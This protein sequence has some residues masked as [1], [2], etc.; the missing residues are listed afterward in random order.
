VD[1]PPVVLGISP[2]RLD[3][4]QQAQIKLYG[5][6]PAQ[7]EDD[8]VVAFGD[9]TTSVFP[10]A[11]GG[12]V[13]TVPGAVTLSEGQMVPFTV[14]ARKRSG[15]FGLWSEDVDLQEQLAV[16]K[17]KPFSCTIETFEVRPD[18]LEKVEAE[19]L[20]SYDAASASQAR[21]SR[22][23]AAADL[24]TQTVRDAASYDPSTAVVLATGEKVF[25][26]G[27]GCGQG[28]SA[29]ARIVESGRAVEID[30]EAPALSRR[31]QIDGWKIQTCEANDT[32]ISLT[33]KPTF[34]AARRDGGALLSR[35][36][37]TLDVGYEGVQLSHHAAAGVPWSVRVSCAFA[38]GPERWQTR[39][40]VLTSDDLEERARGIGARAKA[41]PGP[42]SSQTIKIALEPFDPL[43]FD[44][45]LRGDETRGPSR[46]PRSG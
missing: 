20:A 27:A 28:P 8:V 33:L 22:R 15:L 10:I 45:Q 4:S 7:S 38:E 26:D 17:A 32:R 35:Q 37:E 12:A 41:E 36:K 46:T 40:M 21:Q 43:R 3:A 31:V 1:F 13:F 42:S 11:S 18:L 24:F 29:S 5:H 6:L 16:G 14:R 44:D 9:K 25:A 39:T 30:L 23:V 34:L 2:S 19:K